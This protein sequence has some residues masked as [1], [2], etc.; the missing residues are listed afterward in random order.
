MINH[1]DDLAL[2]TD[3]ADPLDRRLEEVY[4]FAFEPAPFDVALYTLR[5]AWSPTSSSSDSSTSTVFNRLGDGDERLWS[6]PDTLVVLALDSVDDVVKLF[7][8]F[9]VFLLGSTSVAA[10]M[11]LDCRRKAEMLLL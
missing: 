1:N 9:V 11:E 8:L 5:H 6:F 10:S 3:D 7:V 2:G 4:A